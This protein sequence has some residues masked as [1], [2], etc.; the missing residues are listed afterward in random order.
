MCVYMFVF[1]FV[2]V[3]AHTCVLTNHATYVE[4]RGQLM[5]LSLL[6][7][8]YGAWGL[9]STSRA[10]Q[11]VTLPT[12]PSHHPQGQTLTTSQEKDKQLHQTVSR[13]PESCLFSKTIH[14]WPESDQRPK[15]NYTAVRSHIL[16]VSCYERRTGM[17]L[18][19]RV[20]PFQ[21]QRQGFSSQH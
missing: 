6:L 12:E 16:W 18:S 13:G 3:H 1:V 9:S 21:A 19:G 5:G 17:Q 15:S 20:L 4:V 11:Q 2:C 7:P 14:K 10:W 8:S